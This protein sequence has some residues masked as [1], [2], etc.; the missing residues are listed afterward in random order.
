MQKSKDEYI[1][2]AD[3]TKKTPKILTFVLQVLL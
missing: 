1:L 2:F 3:E